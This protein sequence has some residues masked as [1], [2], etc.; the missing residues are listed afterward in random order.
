MTFAALK[1]ART[2]TDLKISYLSVHAASRSIL[3]LV[4]AG[5]M[6]DRQLIYAVAQNITEQKE[7]RKCPE[8]GGER[9][10]AL[11]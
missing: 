9:L 6:L 4:R 5:P 2:S 11:R 1:A 3:A 7:G 10:H 8:A